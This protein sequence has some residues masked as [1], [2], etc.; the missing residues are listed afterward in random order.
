MFGK[1]VRFLTVG[2]VWG[3]GD[4]WDMVLGPGWRQR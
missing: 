2:A 1:R 3:E 4:V